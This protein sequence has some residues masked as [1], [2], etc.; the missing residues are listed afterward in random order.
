M[1]H[2]TRLE[3]PAHIVLAWGFLGLVCRYLAIVSAV[4]SVRCLSEPYPFPVG[5]INS[6][7]A[8]VAAIIVAM[9]CAWIYIWLRETDRC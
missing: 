4:F 5:R 7:E 8:G 3:R 1:Y 9:L 6:V 2:I